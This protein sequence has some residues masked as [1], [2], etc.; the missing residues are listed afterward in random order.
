M[1]GALH[2]GPARQAAADSGAQDTAVRS[3]PSLE[4][5]KLG[6]RLL[7]AV[8]ED[9]AAQCRMLRLLEQQEATITRPSSPE[10]RAATDALEQELERIPFRKGQRDQ[11]FKNLGRAFG[12]D[13]KA[14]TLGSIAE[15]LGSAC[16]PLEVE[17]IL[18][19]EAILEVQKV[20]RRVAALIRMHREI[21]RDVLNAVL[22]DGSG[23]TPFEGGT[24]ID[25]EV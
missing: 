1:S 16:G 10:F 7:V 3:T 15:R 12:V 21:T 23:K 13:F 14:L 17:R 19:R 18:L 5:R 4:I 6:N 25:A 24:L 22:G 11:A 2:D 9:V 20:N 8:R